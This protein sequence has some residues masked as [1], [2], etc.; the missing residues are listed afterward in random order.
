MCEGLRVRRQEL[1]EEIGGKHFWTNKWVLIGFDGSRATAP[2]SMENEKAFCAPNYGF[3]KEAKYG[4]KKS[5]GLRRKRIAAHKIANPEPQVWITMM[6]HMGMRLP[7][8]W[9]LRP[10]NSSERGQVQ[11][12]LEQEEFPE[13]TLFCGGA[14]FVGYPLWSSILAAGKNFLVRVGGNVDLIS[15]YANIQKLGGGI[16]LCWPK[17][18][19]NS[20]APPLRLR[21]LQVQ[22]GKTMMW[23]LT[24]VLDERKLTSKQIIEY[25]KLRWLIEVEFRGLKQTIDKHK[26]RCRNNGRL[27][28]ELDWSLQGMAYAELLAMRAQS[29]RAE[30]ANESFKPRDRSLAEILRVLCRYMRKLDQLTGPDALMNDLGHAV[31][32]RYHN[33]TDKRA[34]YRPKNPDIN[35]L[36]NPTIRK[37]TPE[38]KKKLE[39]QEPKKAA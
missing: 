1:A 14:G 34:R 36:G 13:E 12:M 10:S 7:W 27:L 5:K 20:G 23:Q 3:G 21:L 16:V 29:S 18:R 38:E 32:Q 26:L 17:D 35:P 30:K 6:W 4:K 39:L 19:M 8:T 15:E 25:Y 37:L 31:V 33:R 2:R 22:V 9:R 24:S 28:A 11:E